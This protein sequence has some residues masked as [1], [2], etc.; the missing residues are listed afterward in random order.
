[1]EWGQHGAKDWVGR[2]AENSRQ[3]ALLGLWVNAREKI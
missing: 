3:L 2:N 1:V